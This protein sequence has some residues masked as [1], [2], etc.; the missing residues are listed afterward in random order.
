MEK[1]GITTYTLI[2][3]YK[4]QSKTIY[5]LKHEKNITTATIENLCNILDCTPNDIFTFK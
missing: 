2:Q 4:I 3:K 1:K 5:N